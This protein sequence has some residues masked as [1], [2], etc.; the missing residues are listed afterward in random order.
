[1]PPF[2]R[3]LALPRDLPGDVFAMAGVALCVALGFGVV[4][5]AIPLFATQFG[6]GATLAGAVVSAFACL[7]FLSGLAAGRLSDFLGERTALMLGLIVVAISSLIAGL[8]QSYPQ[9]IVLRGVGGI[10][11]AIFGIGA[12]G[13][14][15]RAAGKRMRGRAISIYRSGFL[16]GGIAGPA[17]GGAVLG[18]SLRA[19]FFLYA[20]TLGIATVVALIFVTKP[21]SPSGTATTREIGA[22][23]ADAADA[24][25]ARADADLADGNAPDR[26]V[27]E[28]LRTPE[29]QTALLTNLAVGLTVLGVRSTAVP[30]LMVDSLHVAP[31]WVGIAFVSSAI[32][33]T[34]LMLPAGRF[35]D[36]AGRRAAILIGTTV[37]AA[38]LVLL[39]LGGSLTMVLIAMGVFGAGAAFLGS[40]PGALVGDM[41]GQRT[42]TVIAIFNMAS[43]LGAVAGPV[44]AGWLIDT[45]SF[46]AAF[47][48]AAAVV[49]A[50]G[51]LGLRLPRGRPQRGD[52]TLNAT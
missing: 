41:V 25:D 34:A 46:P 51:L 37:S 40:A 21:A 38:G 13:L 44:L 4:A 29:Y 39:A 6:V 12:M 30:L 17:L 48:M 43:D 20:G 14:V 18:I 26:S 28:L 33:Q 10:G 8:A 9:L 11:S 35:V 45:G 27:R 5:P 1:M 19:P 42:G 49:L 3:R 47:G 52:K 31:G 50:A 36:T 15:L 7:R 32:V 24:P 2:R 16:V 23:D 22:D